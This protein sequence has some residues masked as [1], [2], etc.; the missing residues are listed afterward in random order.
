MQFVPQHKMYTATFVL[1]LALQ[2]RQT[3]DSRVVHLLC[4]CSGER[5]P[6]EADWVVFYFQEL[7]TKLP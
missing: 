6:A 2:D 1:P 7:I 4:Y 5:E 3:W